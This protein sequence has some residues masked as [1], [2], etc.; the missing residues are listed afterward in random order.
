MGTRQSVRNA[1]VFGV[2]LTEMILILLFLVFLIAKNAIDA[3]GKS[4]DLNATCNVRLQA[5]QKT[6]SES[7]RD[8]AILTKENGKLKQWVALLMDAMGMKP[9]PSDDPNFMD[10]TA[11][12]LYGAK[13]GIGKPNCLSSNKPALDVKMDDG[14]MAASLTTDYEAGDAGAAAPHL[15]HLVT[16]GRIP[17]KTFELEAARIRAARSDC[18]FSV[19][20]RDGTTTKETYKPQMLL[21]ERF[22]RRRVVG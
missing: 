9:L 7:E 21:I 17:I 4:V 16:L 3:H 15:E 19:L 14:Y 22:F 11:K 6:L 20:I 5:C 13:G 1:Q 12:R 10:D 18:I 8:R 2:S